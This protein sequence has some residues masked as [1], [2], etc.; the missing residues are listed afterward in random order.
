MHVTSQGNGGEGAK[1][2]G[3]KGALTMI[4]GGHWYDY[5]AGSKDKT[6]L[7]KIISHMLENTPLPAK[8]LY[9]RNE[10]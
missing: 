9:F 2:R 6:G 1:K 10:K 4:D 5:K 7:S 8:S 3:N